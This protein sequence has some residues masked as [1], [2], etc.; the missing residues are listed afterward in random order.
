MTI[1]EGYTNENVVP[2][3]VDRLIGQS[4]NFQLYFQTRDALIDTIVSK[5]FENAETLTP[6]HCPP[7]R[8]SLSPIKPDPKRLSAR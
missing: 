7:V 8:T 1:D 6:R 2:P 3:M 5:L 4:K